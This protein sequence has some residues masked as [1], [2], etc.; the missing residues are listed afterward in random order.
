MD[1]RGGEPD[2]RGT[3]KLCASDELGEYSKLII[4]QGYKRYTEYLYTNMVHGGSRLCKTNCNG[5]EI[6]NGEAY[7]RA[8]EWVKSE[9]IKL[10]IKE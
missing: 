2:L 4:R 8:K 10:S 5:C 3:L 9:Q 7:G 1:R 6:M